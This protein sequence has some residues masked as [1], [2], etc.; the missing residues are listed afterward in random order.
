MSWHGRI[1]KALELIAQGGHARILVHSIDDWR[2]LLLRAGVVARHIVMP[3]E[4]MVLVATLTCMPSYSRV[5]PSEARDDSSW[6]SL[7]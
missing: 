6:D 5:R 4:F 1:E 7:S 3:G 2:S